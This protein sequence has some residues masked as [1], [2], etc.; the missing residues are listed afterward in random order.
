MGKRHHRLPMPH[1]LLLTQSNHPNLALQNPQQHRPE[2]Q[3]TCLKCSVAGV[4]PKG[5]TVHRENEI[6]PVRKRIMKVIQK[7]IRLVIL[8]SPCLLL[9]AEPGD[10]PAAKPTADTPVVKAAAAPDPTE[11]VSATA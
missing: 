6:N 4:R 2:I 11:S 1:S 8:S 3:M 9:A 10:A 5:E 7:L